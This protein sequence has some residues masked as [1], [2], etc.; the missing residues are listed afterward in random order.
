MGLWGN[1][2][3]LQEFQE[4]FR[5]QDISKQLYN[6]STPDLIKEIDRRNKAMMDGEK[7]EH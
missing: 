2:E 5:Q 7:N 4:E 1:R 6:Y 3:M